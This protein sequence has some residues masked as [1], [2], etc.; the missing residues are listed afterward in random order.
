MRR[1]HRRPP[2]QKTQGWATSPSVGM[3]QCLV[4]QVPRSRRRANLGLPGAAHIADFAMCGFC[5]SRKAWRSQAGPLTVALIICPK[6]IVTPRLPCPRSTHAFRVLCECVGAASVSLLAGQD[7]ISSKIGGQTGR[8]LA[9]RNWKLG[10]RP[11]VPRFLPHQDPVTVTLKPPPGA[12]HIA[13]FAMC[14]LSRRREAG[15]IG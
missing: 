1:Q 10:K 15:L 5:C 6:S 7:N 12:P 2:L 9:S 14:G 4:P 3:V 8:S 11:S 13:H